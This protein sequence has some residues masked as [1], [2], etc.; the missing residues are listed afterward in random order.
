M[1][2][3]VGTL[4]ALAAV[5]VAVRLFALTFLH[6]LN[7]DEVEYFRATDWVRQGLV[8]FRDFWEHHTPLM[9]FVF[10]PV[11][12]LTN[13]PGAD[14]I[15]LMR[16][17]QVP[18][19][20]V[21]FWLV[22]RLMVRAGIA[23]PARWAA[24]V[25]ALTSSLLMIS[26]ME[27]RV[28]TLGNALYLGGLV[29]LL[30]PSSRGAFLAGA[31]FCLA[32][33]AN[34]RL[35]PLLAVTAIAGTLIDVEQ[36]RWKLSA[37]PLWLGAG[38]VAVLGVA[39]TYFAVTGS[40]VALYQHVW[41]ENYI[42]ERLAERVPM[43]FLHRILVPFGVR[44]YGSGASFQPM[45][46]DPGGVAIVLAGLAGLLRSLMTLRRPGVLALLALLQ[47]ANAFFVATMKFVYHY[48]LQMVVL[49]MLPFVG[50]TVAPMFASMRWR[51]VVMAFVVAAAVLSIPI[52]LLRG[53]ELE[54]QYQDRIMREAHARTA[55]GAS[56]FDG[57]G[58]AIRREP[59]YRFWF[60]PVLARQLVAHQH[61]PPYS[62][63][64]WIADP[65]AAV[66]SDRN[67][68]VWLAT[69][70]DLGSYVVHHYLP[71][72]RNLLIPALS[73][74]LGAR[75]SADWIV[76]A[77]GRYRIVA[78]PELAEHP[79]FRYPL[80]QRPELQ[81]RL[82]VAAP[83]PRDDLQWLVDG[84]TVEPNGTLDLRQ[85][86]RVSVLSSAAEPLGV[87]LL[88]G[89]ERE[90]FRQPPPGVSIDAEGERVWHVPRVLLR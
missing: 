64:S 19:W 34:L 7:W 65:P 42:G 87:F 17:A 2:E 18:L 40:L 31:L 50:A 77:D 84:R 24:I 10:A 14:A 78:A 88:P 41:V 16:W 49:L 23:T 38:V 11:T 68:V 25:L 26:A 48:H 37:R 33:L 27:Y 74:R 72:W 12:A 69:H 59:A 76:P 20:I 52:V 6:P 60:L 81:G 71:V 86:S 90:W 85:G 79:W 3:R 67:A 57:V 58:W 13:S 47:I 73:A 83:N 29:L 75:D 36:A 62:I 5:A 44:M 46:I 28:D 80:A 8:P 45:G 56:V 22:N 9:W 39:V 32:G 70:R 66:I 35:G 21:S 89:T 63:R 15:V 43:A 1:K 55:P 82:V 61:A 53:K 30:R 51:R 4:L 54:L